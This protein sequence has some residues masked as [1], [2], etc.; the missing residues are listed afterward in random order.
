[1]SSVFIPLGLAFLMLCVGLETRIADFTALVRAP[2]VVAAGSAAQILG[3]PVLAFL[4][5]RGFELPP[6]HALGLMLVAAA[7]GGVTANFVTL[8]ARG[9][10]AVAVTIT[11]LGSL[12]APV[13]VP[14]VV[15]L[16]SAGLGGEAVAPVLPFGSTIAAVFVTTVVPLAVGS[17]LTERRGTLA[18]RIR[19]GMRKA[20]GVVFLLIVTTAIVSQ[21]AALTSSWRVVGAATVALNL[22]AMGLCVAVGLAVGA[23]RRGLVASA[24]TGGLRNI[25]LALTVAIGLLGRPDLAVAATVY[26]FTMNATALGTALILRRYGRLVGDQGH[27]AANGL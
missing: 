7:P 12:L 23:V 27:E 22:A 2:W 13:T 17:W 4:V 6:V 19:P 5:A 14:I 16:A 26:V 1:M 18:D 10:V 24:I 9:D 20:S 11:V 25:A 21:W 15:G 8:M 3:L